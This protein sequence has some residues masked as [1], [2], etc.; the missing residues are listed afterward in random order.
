MKIKGDIE[1]SQPTS[2]LGHCRGQ[3]LPAVQ[4]FAG[5]GDVPGNAALLLA[6]QCLL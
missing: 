4:L 6:G 3:Y 1:K 5:C 2:S